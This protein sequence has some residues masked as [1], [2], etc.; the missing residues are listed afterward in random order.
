MVLR[1]TPERY[2]KRAIFALN[3]AGQCGSDPEVRSHFTAFCA[4]ACQSVRESLSLYYADDSTKLKLVVTLPHVE[5]LELV[6]NHDLHGHPLLLC[7][8]RIVSFMMQSGKH[9]VRLESSHGVAV[10]IQ[11]KRK[12]FVRLDPKDVKHARV[13][14][15]DA[16]V[17][18][19]VDGE[20]YIQYP[21]ASG[22]SVHLLTAMKEFLLAAEYLLPIAG[23]VDTSVAS[24]SSSENLEV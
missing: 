3:S 14:F 19:S 10:S 2:I 11:N 12:P 17:M 9:S 4:H 15:A 16:L 22:K 24:K 8:P 23:M 13:L 1:E 7:D 18:N 21:P 6:R 5:M 20:L